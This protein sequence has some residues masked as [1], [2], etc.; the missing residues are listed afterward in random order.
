MP[1]PLHGIR[2][3]DLTSVVLGPFATMTLADLGADVIK[4][5][6]PEGDMVR[7][8]GVGRHAGMGPM[9]LQYN[10]NKRSVVLDLKS[11]GGKAALL[12]LIATADAVLHNMRPQA[13]KGL[14]L[15]YESVR[16]VKPDIVYCAAYGFGED[17]PYAGK[18]AFDDIIQGVSGLAAI[19]EAI[20]DMP[21]YVP[22]IIADK[23][24]GL[25]LVY[26]CLAAL[27]HRARTGEGQFVE[28]P[29][30][31]TMVAYNMVE[32]I[33]GQSFVPPT[34][35]SGYTRVLAPERK[36]HKTKDGYIGILPYSDRNWR[37]LFILAGREDLFDDPRFK[38]TNART[39]NAGYVY[40]E[41]GK[42]MA[43]KTNAEWIKL[44]DE[45]SIPC[46]PVNRLMDLFDDP[47][48]RAVGMFPEADHPSEG[49]IKTI[50]IAYSF[51][52]TPCEVTRQA[53][54]LGEH[55]GE[56]LRELGMSDAEIAALEPS[57][58]VRRA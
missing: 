54:R 56:V 46:A 48:L 39:A 49:R 37:D 18:A 19:V 33:W 31:E 40:G 38:T 22:S 50:R 45:R 52:A 34:G 25:T 29:M 13:M 55:S 7:G 44:C 42:I 8:I 51:G 16:M 6:S 26:C 10:R 41:V 36:P 11:E 28:I 9:H 35:P 23:T 15:D 27:L 5:E 30:F 53:P 12:K 1:G 14:G 32:H 20:S 3:V 21:R 47:H 24:T 58:A 4:V 43:T 57:G 17:G 2:I